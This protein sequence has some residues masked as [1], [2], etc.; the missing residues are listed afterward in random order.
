MRGFSLLTAA[1][2]VLHAR[3]LQSQIR[4]EWGGQVTGTTGRPAFVGA[5][6]LWAWRPGTRD[7]MMLHGALGAAEHQAALRVEA[8]WH[9]MLNPRTEKGVGAYL[10]GGVAGQFAGTNHGWLLL[11]AGLEQNPGARRGWT[12][13]L[14]VGGGVRFT[15]GY[16][17]RK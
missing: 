13:E 17:W 11:M 8:A 3:P 15:V 6:P 14:G 9:F 2:L 5:G 10:G 16:R 1:A 7:R 12:V 4:H